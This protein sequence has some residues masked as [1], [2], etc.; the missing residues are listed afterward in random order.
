[1]GRGT[2]ARSSDPCNNTLSSARLLA[3]LTS[4]LEHLK[5]WL[6]QILASS[7]A[8]RRTQTKS[9]SCPY[10][11]RLVPWVALL[12]SQMLRLEKGEPPLI[13]TSSSSL[14]FQPSLSAVHSASYRF[15]NSIH[16]SGSFCHCF[17][18]EPP[19]PLIWTAALAFCIP[20]LTFDPGGP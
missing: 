17:W 18:A 10:K 20:A 9:S 5:K 4:H 19:L 3:W 15:L 13:F 7:S 8:L 14:A 6:T 1:M 11:L 12:S 2:G 16:F